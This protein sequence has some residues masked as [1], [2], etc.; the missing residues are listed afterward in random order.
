MAA[1]GDWVT[2]RLNDF[3]YFEKPPLQYWTTAAFFKLFGEHDWA[4]RLWTAL[5]AIAGVVLVFSA[6]GRLFSAEAG[7]LCAAALA[8]GP[9]SSRVRAADPPGR[10]LAALSSA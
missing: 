10:G 2:P 7:A 3:K 8:G 5:T 1:S 4:A 6:G 9:P